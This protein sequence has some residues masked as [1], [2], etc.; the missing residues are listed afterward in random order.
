MAFGCTHVAQPP[1][2]SASQ[3]GRGMRAGVGL[4][5]ECGCGMAREG[6]QA[7]CAAVWPATKSGYVACR[8]KSEPQWRFINNTANIAVFAIPLCFS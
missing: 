2:R 3:R 4:G 7:P 5:R 8:R 6:A 1:A